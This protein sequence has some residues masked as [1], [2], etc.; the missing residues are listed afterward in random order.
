MTPSAIQTNATKMTDQ[1]LI[2]VCGKE[3]VTRSSWMAGLRYAAVITSQSRYLPR[4]NKLNQG[5][6]TPTRYS[7]AKGRRKNS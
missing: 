3:Q 5:V 2:V 4:T 7:K 1:P 6:L